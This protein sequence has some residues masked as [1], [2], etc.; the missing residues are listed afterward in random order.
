MCVVTRVAIGSR[1]GY[2]QVKVNAENTNKR[3]AAYI[4]YRMILG[5]TDSQIFDAQNWNAVYVDPFGRGISLERETFLAV[6][7]VR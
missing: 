5:V 1:T 6:C 4:L 2:H 7:N 3:G